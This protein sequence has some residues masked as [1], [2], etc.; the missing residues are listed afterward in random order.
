MLWVVF[1]YFFVNGTMLYADINGTV[2]PLYLRGVN[3][4]GFETEDH[5]V[6]GLWARNYQDMLDQMK[7][8][9]FNAIRLPFCTDSVLNSSV[10]YINYDL[11]PDLEGLG[12]LDIMKK[13][14]EEA[15]KRGIYV[16]LDYHRIGCTEIEPLWYTENFTEQDYINTWLLVAQE[17][18]DYPN[19]IGADLK[20]E[21]H[22]WY[23]DGAT[24]GYN[25][26]RDWDKGAARI[27]QAILEVAPHWLLFVEG[28]QI[29]NPEIDS[30]YEYGYNSWWGG[31]L[32]AA[33]QYPVDLPRDKL[34]YSP[35][36]Y[37]P[38][39]YPQPYFD[40][41]TFPDNMPEIWETHFGYLSD[42]YPVVIGE[43]GGTYEG[44]DQIWQQAI[45]D[46]M[47]SKQLC[48]FFYWA[49]NPNSGDTGGI[50]ED[51]WT[52]VDW[53]KYNNLKR[54]FDCGQTTTETTTSQEEPIS[55]Y[56]YTSQVTS[57]WGSGFCIEFTI[58][59]NGTLPVNWTVV[60]NKTSDIE[61]TSYWN[62]LLT[63]TETQVILEAAQEL[64]PSSSIGA[65]FCANRLATTLTEL[66][67]T[68]Q[69][70]SHWRRGYCAKVTVYNNLS[71]TV[72]WQVTI[73]KKYNLVTYWNA[74]LI[75][76]DA[77]S[78]TFKGADWNEF[79]LPGA[80]TEFGLCA[81]N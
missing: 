25:E 80:T 64:A 3:W 5:V 11:N 50:L 71:S 72:A 10:R 45:V 49:W 59:N 28:T 47:L 61:I 66:P 74:E 15:G 33:Q 23:E 69:Y 34:V 55:S 58:Y 76:E 52:T 42:E 40:D 35:H 9:G 37:G 51:D 77:Y 48:S 78:W 63:E 8:L 53:D 75:G 43:F 1:A 46:W 21:P 60:W 68:I 32:M 79:L 4:F 13:I 16:L 18:K 67:Y 62:A 54:L 31:N 39:V 81:Y 7:E 56:Y 19:V 2:E 30:S 41:P 26:T 38:D 57:D 44:Q 20:N 65:G 27:G 24:W 29:T 14:V 12:S 17:F 6:H 73:P 22:G 70:Y 36:V